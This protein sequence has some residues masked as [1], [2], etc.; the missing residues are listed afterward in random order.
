MSD[1]V[2]L[3]IIGH[4]QRVIVER[5]CTVDRIPECETLRSMGES[6]QCI[7]LAIPNYLPGM[8]MGFS[9]MVMMIM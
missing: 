3:V 7:F 4:R 2:S 5:P 1:Y 9:G 8:E 6:A